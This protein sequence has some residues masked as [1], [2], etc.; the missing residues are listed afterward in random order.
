MGTIQNKEGKIYGRL[1]VIRY[2]GANKYGQTLW[3]CRC[4]CGSA[5]VV[6]SCDLTGGSVRSCGCLHRDA[7]IK[8][9]L[10]HGF[11]RQS[12]SILSAFYDR[13]H[14]M[15]YWC[16]NKSDANYGGKGIEC[17]WATLEAF[18]RDMWPSFKRHVRK[19]GTWELRLTGSTV[20]KGI[21]RRI[22][23][24]LHV[25]SKIKTNE[26]TYLSP[27][28][29]RPSALQHGL[30]NSG[31]IPL[32]LAGDYVMG[33]AVQMRYLITNHETRQ[34][35]PTRP[36]PRPL[37]AQEDPHYARHHAGDLGN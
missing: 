13:Y 21:V 15:R 34:T 9:S 5:K 3:H 17:K 6:R 26:Q 12:E 24:G 1:R 32:L 18:Y 28:G 29:E 4:A 19:H 16:R 30:A 22:A 36:H 23:V 14:S 10:K 31:L 25:K 35:N 2:S 37:Q 8:R 20:R 33:G 11:T 7:T 27:T